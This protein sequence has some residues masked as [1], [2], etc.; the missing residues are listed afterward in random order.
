MSA[1][2][3]GNSD[4][5]RLYH[6]TGTCELLEILERLCKGHEKL[7]HLLRNHQVLI[8]L[9]DFLED[10]ERNVMTALMTDDYMTVLTVVKGL[11]V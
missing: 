4:E 11:H 5:E 7:Q 9:V 10:I 2:S 3:C 6:G 1:E 8:V